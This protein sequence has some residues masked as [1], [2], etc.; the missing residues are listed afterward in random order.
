MARILAR[1]P[2]LAPRL[3]QLIAASYARSRQVAAEQT[4]LAAA[5]FPRL[6]PYELG[7]IA[8]PNFLPE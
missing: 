5:E 4:K 7:Q 3:P 6:C 1:Q 2:G 8:D